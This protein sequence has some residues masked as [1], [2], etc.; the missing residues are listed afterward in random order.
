MKMIIIIDLYQEADRLFDELFA[1]YAGKLHRFIL[2]KTR[3]PELAADLVQDTFVRMLEKGHLDG[4]TN[5]ASFAYT[6]AQNLLIDHS[7]LS[8]VRRREEVADEFLLEVPDESSDLTS[9]SE[10]IQ[11]LELFENLLL[12][13]PATQR[14]IFVL[15]RMEGW[16]YAEIATHL[17]ISQSKVAKDIASVSLYLS[18]KIIDFGL[19]DE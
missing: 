4:V 17:Q 9:H 10:H 18:E 15:S 16:T 19:L 1:R 5:H 12:E 14:Q 11:Q 2:R 7:R 8:Y 6:I 3:D 13:L